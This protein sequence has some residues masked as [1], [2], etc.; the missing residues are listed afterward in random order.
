[1]NQNTNWLLFEV[2]FNYSLLIFF[3][4]RSGHLRN[5][6]IRLVMWCLEFRSVLNHI[7][8]AVTLSSTCACAKTRISLVRPSNFYINNKLIKDIMRNYTWE[9]PYAWKHGLAYESTAHMHV[10]LIHIERCLS[11]LI[12][13]CL[14]ERLSHLSFPSSHLHRS[15]SLFYSFTHK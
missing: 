2:A 10:P 1:M 6:M 3:S 7:T 13:F 5:E 11:L 15:H 8:S 9:A 4:Q 14:S 12:S